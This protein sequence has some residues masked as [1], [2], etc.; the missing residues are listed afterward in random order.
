VGF[1]VGCVVAWAVDDH[2]PLFIALASA[3]LVLAVLS[4]QVEAV[5]THRVLYHGALAI[6]V[7]L[8]TGSLWAAVAGG[9]LVP[10]WAAVG[11]AAMV[12]AAAVTADLAYQLVAVTAIAS[13][14][15]LAGFG[16]AEYS[17]DHPVIGM[18]FVWVGLAGTVAGVAAMANSRIVI[19]LAG[20][21]AGVVGIATGLSLADA[22]T[23]LGASADMVST[24]R[25]DL[26]LGLA[27]VGLG[28][29]STGVGIM[30]LI[31]S[32]LALGIGLAGLGLCDLLGG[33]GVVA[34]F[35]DAP[36]TLAFGFGLIGL[37]GAGIAGAWVVLRSNKLAL[38]PLVLALSML[39][40]MAIDMM[41]DLALLGVLVLW[42]ALAVAGLGVW[43]HVP[44]HRLRRS[45]P[46]KRFRRWG[47][48]ALQW[49]EPPSDSS[50]DP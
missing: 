9:D 19:G 17:N 31:R 15:A 45:A 13:G 43:M 37:G 36:G 8:F 44:G 50:S 30:V 40:T 25:S 1:V 14:L 27:G 20:V 21:A 3:F 5:R 23:S 22:S 12:V 34:G 49:L 41:G 33:V 28:L 32:W 46:A 35:P 39:G 48:D 18:V 24:M 4:V 2:A 7:V 16:A 42:V 38:A 47:G 10:A 11:T 29:A 6:T 26:A